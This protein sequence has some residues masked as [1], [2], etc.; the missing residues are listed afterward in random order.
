MDITNEF[1]KRKSFLNWSVICSLKGIEI[2]DQLSSNPRDLTMILNG[3]EL[4]PINFF[5]RI[6]EEFDR[7]VEEKANEKLEQAKHDIL[8]EY[9]EKVDEI[10]NE[11]ENVLWESI[12]GK[13]ETEDK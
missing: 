5:K 6:E 13:K 10:T 2:T 11:I 9:Q 1:E 3:V 12:R 4:N 7:A 8:D